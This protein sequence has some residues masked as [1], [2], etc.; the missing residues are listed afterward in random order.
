MIRSLSWCLFSWLALIDMVLMTIGKFLLPEG[1]C[2][3]FFTG[4]IFRIGALPRFLPSLLS[5]LV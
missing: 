3:G 1:V 5:M 4:Q 2:K